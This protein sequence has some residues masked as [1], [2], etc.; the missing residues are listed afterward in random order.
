[1]ARFNTLSVGTLTVDKIVQ[2]TV[3][4]NSQAA[5]SSTQVAAS[6]AVLLVGPTTS[7]AKATA[8]Y[9]T[10]ITIPAGMRVTSV[11]SEVVVAS[12]PQT[13]HV[14]K[15]GDAAAGYDQWDASFDVTQAAGTQE[16]GT[17]ANAS[18]AALFGKLYA[19]ATP[20]RVT[21]TVVG[22]ASAVGSYRLLV[23]GYMPA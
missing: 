13:T 9:E 23:R 5:P 8:A 2:R 18:A 1:M 22:T 12:V 10:G 16:V 7:L 15:V 11:A 21:H 4:P 6:P 20:L 19:A 14:I 3:P 17:G